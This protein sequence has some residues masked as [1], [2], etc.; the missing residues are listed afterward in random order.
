MLGLDLFSHLVFSSSRW[1][2]KLRKAAFA[3]G[4]LRLPFASN[5]LLPPIS[6]YQPSRHQNGLGI[7]A[8]SLCP[9]MS[10]NPDSKTDRKA[11]NKIK[12][13]RNA[14]NYKYS[15]HFDCSIILR[16]L[17]YSENITA[18]I[19]LVFLDPPLFARLVLKSATSRLKSTRYGFSSFVRKSRQFFLQI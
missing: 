11:D 15:T 6:V 13:N 2:L 12:D 1:F 16:G 4:K 17:T 5:F 8:I 10:L 18:S 14:R 7:L 3:W 19:S 9:R